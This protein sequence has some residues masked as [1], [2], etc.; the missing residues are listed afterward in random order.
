MF[1]AIAQVQDELPRAEIQ[2][3]AFELL[4]EKADIKVLFSF[5]KIPK[6]HACREKTK[7]LA[8]MFALVLTG[9]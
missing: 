8:N 7:Q 1:Q 9:G 4:M 3:L 5:S 2:A 6:Y